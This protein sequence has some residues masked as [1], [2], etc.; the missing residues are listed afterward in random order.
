[1]FLV[2]VFLEN[3]RHCSQNSSLFVIFYILNTWEHFDI[4][5]KDVIGQF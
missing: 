5:V 2:L 3:L 1:M 4:V